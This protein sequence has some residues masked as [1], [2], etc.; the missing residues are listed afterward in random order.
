MIEGIPVRSESTGRASATSTARARPPNTYGRR[1]SSSAQRARRGERCSPL[2]T[3]GSDSRSTLGPSLAST[4]G[5]S[6][7]V[8]ASTKMTATMMPRDVERKAGLG[9]SITAESETSTVSPE[10][11]TALPAVSIVVATAST[12]LSPW[13]KWALRNRMTMN[14]A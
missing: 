10:K 5:S 8:A 4:A 9:T 2:C 12:G 14:R 11:R 7:S 3:Q 13:P 6:V 1:Q